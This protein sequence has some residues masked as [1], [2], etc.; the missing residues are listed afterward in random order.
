MTG[1]GPNQSKPSTQSQIERI[2]RYFSVGEIGDHRR[3]DDAW[4]VEANDQHGFDI[5]D[6]TGN[7]YPIPRPQ[8]NL[9][10]LTVTPKVPLEI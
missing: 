6:I 4:V 1:G 3:L 8:K 9:T 2:Q 10:C 5:Y 7:Y